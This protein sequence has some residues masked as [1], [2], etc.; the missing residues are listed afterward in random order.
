MLQTALD[1][2]S[3]I[4]VYLDETNISAADINRICARL[5]HPERRQYHKF[6]SDILADLARLVDEQC[7]RNAARREVRERAKPVVRLADVVNLADL[8]KPE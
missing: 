1:L 3:T 6:A 2:C 7:K 4:R 5:M 8:F